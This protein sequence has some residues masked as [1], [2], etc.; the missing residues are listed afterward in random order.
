MGLSFRGHD[1]WKYIFKKRS[2]GLLFRCYKAVTISLKITFEWVP[3]SG[4]RFLQILFY[5]T[6]QWVMRSLFGVAKLP[7]S[8]WTQEC[9]FKGDSNGSRFRPISSFNAVRRH[10]WKLSWRLPGWPQFP[11]G[12]NP[13]KCE[14]GKLTEH[15]HVHW[16]WSFR[17][18]YTSF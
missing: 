9:L 6:F 1:S 2:N 18:F 11:K 4:P 16:W 7:Q 8:A 10:M 12:S 13:T 15:M 3:F 5:G 17:T 14:E